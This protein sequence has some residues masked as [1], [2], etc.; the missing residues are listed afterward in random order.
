[1]LPTP[2]IRSNGNLRDPFLCSS[3]TQNFSFP[4]KGCLF[5]HNRYSFRAALFDTEK[6]RV[7]HRIERSPQVVVIATVEE[8]YLNVGIVS[9]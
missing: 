4:E 2:L 6:S 5:L 8:K 3:R 1:M 9:F 7:Q